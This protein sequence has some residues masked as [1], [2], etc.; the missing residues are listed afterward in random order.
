VI[1]LR[2]AFEKLNG[3]GHSRVSGC[4][5]TAQWARRRCL[6]SEKTAELSHFGSAE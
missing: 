6:S 1:G 2:Q 5:K 4:E 3:M